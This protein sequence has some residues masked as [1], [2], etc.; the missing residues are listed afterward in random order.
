[1][2]LQKGPLLHVE[3]PDEDTA[4]INGDL[5]VHLTTLCG[6]LRGLCYRQ[7]STWQWC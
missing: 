7:V 3:S 4:E 1:M 2:L 5:S 6:K